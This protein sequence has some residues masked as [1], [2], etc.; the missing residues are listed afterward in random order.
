MVNFALI[1]AGVG[2]LFGLVTAGIIL[3]VWWLTE[4]VRLKKA[5][6]KGGYLE[7]GKGNDE[8]IGRFQGEGS[9]EHVGEYEPLPTGAFKDG[10]GQQPSFKVYRP[11]Y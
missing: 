6:M 10:T 1:S 11:E 5:K 3:L 4:R 7:N 8:G 9:F 2:V